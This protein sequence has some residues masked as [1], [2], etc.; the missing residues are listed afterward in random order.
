MKTYGIA[1]TINNPSAEHRA[2]FTPALG[3]PGALSPFERRLAQKG[4]GADFSV[5]VGDE[6]APS[7][8]TPHL[9][10]WPAAPAPAAGRKIN[11]RGVACGAGWRVGVHGV[12]C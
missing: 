12:G 3:T 11:I 2:L 8:G 7:T 1:C 4:G 6:T 9:Q 10:V 5:F